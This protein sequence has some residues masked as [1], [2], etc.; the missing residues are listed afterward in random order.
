MLSQAC[1]CGYAGGSS[2]ACGAQGLG[3]HQNFPPF[4]DLPDENDLDENYYGPDGNGFS[5]VPIRHWCFMGEVIE[6]SSDI[7][8]RALL[9]TRF[10]EKV[11]LNFHLEG[12]DTP[13]FLAGPNCSLEPP[14]ASC[15]LVAAP[16]WTETAEFVGR[17]RTLS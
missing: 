17:V 2:V 15:M 16:S 3:N 8:H 13:T 6:A 10:G 5:Y 9:K 14:C 12:A 7:R 11:L 1:E 4:A